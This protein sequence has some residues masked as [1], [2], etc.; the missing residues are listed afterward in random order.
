MRFN[1][2][3]RRRPDAGLVAVERFARELTMIK[4]RGRDWLIGIGFAILNWVFDLVCLVA[5]CAAV[6]AGRATIVL[7][8][9]A[10]IAGIS[11]AS[12]SVIPGGFG[13][14]DAAMILALH[15]GG[16]GQYAPPPPWCST[17]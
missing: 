4:P 13:I 5:C 15:S 7:V 2:V 12:I 8:T 16:V 6:G 3:V 1:R 14:V 10:Y 9:V 17:G 11:A